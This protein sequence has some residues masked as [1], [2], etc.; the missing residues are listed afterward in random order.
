M[1]SAV[2]VELAR[3][4]LHSGLLSLSILKEV[5]PL[6][7]IL[8]HISGLRTLSGLITTLP[9]QREGNDGMGIFQPQPTS[10]TVTLHKPSLSYKSCLSVLFW[11]N[12]T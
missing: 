10:N 3:F 11:A 7:Q 12:S 4:V 1:P 8:E 5:N 6:I 9:S 2:S